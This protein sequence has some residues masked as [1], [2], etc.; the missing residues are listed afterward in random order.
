MAD[1]VADWLNEWLT[2][3]QTGC[4][5]YLWTEWLNVLLA[6]WMTNKYEDLLIHWFIDWL[7]RCLFDWLNDRIN[8]T[9]TDMK[10]TRDWV[11]AE[12]LNYYIYTHINIHI[13]TF[14]VSVS[15]SQRQYIC[16]ANIHNFYSVKYYVHFTQSIRN[17]LQDKMSVYLRIFLRHL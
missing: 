11:L 15:V 14:H 10:A 6:D 5:T 12:Y 1:W 13:P 3:W 4:C 8:T 9:L 16:T 7:T 17:H 2:G